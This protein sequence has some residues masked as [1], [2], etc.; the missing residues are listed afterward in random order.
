MTLCRYLFQNRTANNNLRQSAMI[1]M[2]KLYKRG[3][4]LLVL[5][6]LVYTPESKAVLQTTSAGLVPTFEP[7]RVGFSLD[8][9]I[10]HSW[11]NREK[12]KRVEEMKEE[13]KKERSSSPPSSTK[14]WSK[15]LSAKKLTS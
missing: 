11:T 14:R 2:E 9:T 10:S 7:K 5:Y 6:L 15:R 13:D 12:K 8:E 4:F 1:L 3:I